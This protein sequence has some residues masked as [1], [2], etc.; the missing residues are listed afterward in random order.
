MQKESPLSGSPP[1]L[2]Q[3]YPFIV[4]R[5]ARPASLQLTQ[6]GGA[7][8]LSSSWL[9]SRVAGFKSMQA[10]CTMRLKHPLDHEMLSR[11]SLG[12]QGTSSHEQVSEDQGYPSRC[13]QCPA[14]TKIN[15]ATSH[16]DLLFFPPSEAKSLAEVKA[17]LISALQLYSGTYGAPFKKPGESVRGWLALLPLCAA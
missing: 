7:S 16:P 11:Q 13:C 9:A 14:K 17:A 3:N 8:T 2:T 15:N 4:F 1:V 5:K 10:Y 12:A 6:S